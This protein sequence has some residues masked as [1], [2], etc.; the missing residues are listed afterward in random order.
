MPSLFMAI[1][2]AVIIGMQ[3]ILYVNKAKADPSNQVIVST[4]VPKCNLS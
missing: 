1:E 2:G 4:F 3:D